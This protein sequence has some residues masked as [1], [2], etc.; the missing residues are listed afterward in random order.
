[1]GHWHAALPFERSSTLDSGGLT[2]GKPYPNIWTVLQKWILAL[3]ARTEEEK[4]K[5]GLYMS[6]LL[7]LVKELGETK[8]LGGNGV[9]LNFLLI[10]SLI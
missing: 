9:N 4:E 3:P 5:Q 8:G 10:R 6:E 2:P 1:M 7:Y